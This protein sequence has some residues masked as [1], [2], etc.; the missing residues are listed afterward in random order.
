MKKDIRYILIDKKDYSNEKIKK[1]FDEFKGDR[2]C[3]LINGDKDIKK[4]TRQ[5]AF[6]YCES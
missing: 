1:I 6:N 4:S 5:I 2:V 3:I